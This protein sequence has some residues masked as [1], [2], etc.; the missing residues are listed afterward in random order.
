MCFFSSSGV[1]LGLAEAIAKTFIVYLLVSFRTFNERDLG[2]RV[3]KQYGRKCQLWFHLRHV[4][5]R[6]AARGHRSKPV[7]RA[8]N[9]GMNSSVIQPCSSLLTARGRAFTRRPS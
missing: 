2:G 4:G 9:R 6:R 3:R 1:S 5:P 7:G 8:L